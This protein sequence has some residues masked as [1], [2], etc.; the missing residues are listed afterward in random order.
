MSQ[1]TSRDTDRIQEFYGPRVQQLIQQTRPQ[2]TQRPVQ[3]SDITEHSRD[4]EEKAPGC[5]GSF[6]A[7]EEVKIF[8]SWVDGFLAKRKSKHPTYATTNTAKSSSSQIISHSHRTSAASAASSI[9]SIEREAQYTAQKEMLEYEVAR[10]SLWGE[11]VYHYKAW[12]LKRAKKKADA[13]RRR[14][15]GEEAQSQSTQSANAAPEQEMFRPETYRTLASPTLE[16]HPTL[17]RNIDNIYPNALSPLTRKPLP[18][19]TRNKSSGEVS[20]H[21]VKINHLP[22]VHNSVHLSEGPWNSPY[23]EVPDLPLR[24]K[25]KSSTVTA[26]GDFM[27]GPS[28]IPQMPAAN[29]T[30]VPS[31]V[32]IPQDQYQPEPLKPDFYQQGR[33][34]SPWTSTVPNDDKLVNNSGPKFSTPNLP[35]TING[36]RASSGPQNQHCGLCGSLN[37]PNTHY[38]QQGLWL[39]SACR[40][41]TFSNERPPSS[42]SVPRKEKATEKR[43][44]TSSSKSREDNKSSNEHPNSI[45][46]NG[47][48]ES[49][50]IT[51]PPM[52]RFTNSNFHKCAWCNNKLTFPVDSPLV[53]PLTPDF[54]TTKPAPLNL[55]K[56]TIDQWVRDHD[57]DPV[58]PMSIDPF[59]NFDSENPNPYTTHPSTPPHHKPTNSKTSLPPAPYPKD[60]IYIS[61]TSTRLSFYPTTPTS[62]TPN[63]PRKDSDTLPPIPPLPSS[64][65]KALPNFPPASSLIAKQTRFPVRISSLSTPAAPTPH[66]FP[67]APPP[68]PNETVHKPKRSS[69]IYP[70]DGVK[71]SRGERDTFILPALQ[72]D[73]RGRLGERESRGSQRSGKRDTGFYDFWEPILEE[74]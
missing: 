67:F 18:T 43:K 56:S 46:S 64:K 26:F 21:V 1:P 53:S 34:N 36:G 19:H 57:N 70:E 60:S 42:F 55:Q 47:H 31:H 6:K 35:G 45:F 24:N 72:F 73:G 8:W 51:Q 12:C 9:A 74:K 2:Q 30:K 58:S 7:G 38:G 66:S 63:H 25:R 69:S 23:E 28:E 10:Y 40:S 32:P 3:L 62:T 22:S 44:Q 4:E 14:A 11:I 33:S 20:K 16:I 5:L 17:A 49:C 41:P 50:N 71:M 15:R 29:L 65:I 37:S 48:C 68:I 54:P 52:Q 39:C 61:P 13:G 59:S 27:R